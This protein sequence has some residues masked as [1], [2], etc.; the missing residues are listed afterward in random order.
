M[1]PRALIPPDRPKITVRPEQFPLEAAPD[2]SRGHVEVVLV[3]IHEGSKRGR[4]ECVP[5]PGL[6]ESAEAIVAAVEA[7]ADNISTGV[8]TR[9][10]LQRTMA[11]GAARNAIDL[12]LWDF[13][14]KRTGSSAW[15]IAGLDV[16]RRLTTAFTICHGSAEAMAAAAAEQAHRPLLKLDL[17][18]IYEFDR[19]LAV[20]MAAPR[21]RLIIDAH[22]GW[23]L[24][25]LVKAMPT[26]AEAGVELIEDP[27]PPGADM[28]LRGIKRL[29]PICA[30]RTC[31]DRSS[32]AELV[33]LYD[34]INIEL[35]RTGGLTEA[36]ALAEQAR[37]E[38]F[39][40]KVGC[41]VGTSLAVA[42]A[43]I[44]AQ[45]ADWI[46]LDAPLRL[47]RDRQPG[48]RYDGSQLYPPSVSLW[49]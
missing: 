26:L 6:G 41:R 7:V 8:I 11:A 13:D 25:S 18:T 49:G 31:N 39:R 4:G 43:V 27:L 45:D 42:P 19:L 20:K 48:L 29:V 1:L 46:D 16:P 3:E 38:G 33:G 30:N 15:Q 23:T 14:A 35:D 24:D 28:K 44:L 32:L 22:E 40:V 10:S 34:A 17:E 2:G 5:D 36:L 9:R 37:D 21:A 47:A 12:A